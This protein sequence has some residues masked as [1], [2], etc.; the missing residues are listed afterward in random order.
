MDTEND[1]PIIVSRK[2]AKAKGIKTYFTGK[3]CKHGHICKRRVDGGC[4]DCTKVILKKWRD[5]N[6]EQLKES[7]AEWA[8]NNKEKRCSTMNAWREA[9]KEHVLN[10]RKSWYEKN[11]DKQSA[12]HKIW[13]IKNRERAIGLNKIWKENNKAHLAVSKKKWSY[14]N[15]EKNRIYRHTRRARMR[16][17]EG[18]H[19]AQDIKDMHKAQGGCCIYCGVDVGEDYHVDHIVPLVKGGSNGKENLQITCPTCNLKKGQKDH[20]EFLSLNGC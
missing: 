12:S 9:N 7:Y 11:K 8:S 14:E 3:P 13:Y 1:T 6:K 15:P 4:V 19:T 10:Y 5:S 20:A 2:E 18:T 16:N 17:S